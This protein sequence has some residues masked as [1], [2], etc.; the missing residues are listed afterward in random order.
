[1]FGAPAVSA[2]TP[3]RHK[4]KAWGWRPVALSGFS[5]PGCLHAR[6]AAQKK[7]KP[8]PYT[9]GT[10]D[11]SR[12]TWM[13][14]L[15]NWGQS[16]SAPKPLWIV[17]VPDGSPHDQPHDPGFHPSRKRIVALKRKLFNILPVCL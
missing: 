4:A 17:S 16:S 2:T 6:A 3:P 11:K 14:L 10:A 13:P 12:R 1:L 8:G 5:R 7:K 15:F 9:T